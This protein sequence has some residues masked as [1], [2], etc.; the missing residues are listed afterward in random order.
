[1]SEP[2]LRLRKLIEHWAEHNDEHRARFRE[3]AEEAKRLGLTEAAE[4]LRQ[5]SEEAAKVSDRLRE[6]LKALGN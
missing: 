5:A 4:K 6:T 2:R 1:M 3:S